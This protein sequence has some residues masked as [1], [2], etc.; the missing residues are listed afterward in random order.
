MSQMANSLRGR[1]SVIPPAGRDPFYVEIEATN[2]DIGAAII[3]NI[4]YDVKAGHHTSA[5]MVG[6]VG[7]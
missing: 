6:M 4:D 7:V 1:V 3:D 5:Y 2:S